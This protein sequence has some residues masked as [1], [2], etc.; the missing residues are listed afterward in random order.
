MTDNIDTFMDDN[1]NYKKQQQRSY[2]MIHVVTE[3]VRCQKGRRGFVT[4]A[5]LEK[6]FV[7]KRQ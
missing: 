1:I 5:A 3:A 4:T 6:T 7:C 2:S